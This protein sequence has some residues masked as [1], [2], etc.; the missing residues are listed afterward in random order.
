MKTN[1]EVEYSHHDNKTGNKGGTHYGTISI[2]A[3][4]I[5]EALDIAEK[6]IPNWHTK[7]CAKEMM[8]TITRISRMPLD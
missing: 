5:R 8:F 2:K 6:D 3:Q 7:E 4:N 1:F